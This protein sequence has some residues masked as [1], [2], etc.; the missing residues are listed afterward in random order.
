MYSSLHL[1]LLMHENVFAQFQTVPEILHTR[2]VVSGLL[3]LIMRQP[4]LYVFVRR[5][6]ITNS[7]CEILADRFTYIF[8]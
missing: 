6:C 4:Y 3:N 1:K 5:Y 2:A 7:F 8:P